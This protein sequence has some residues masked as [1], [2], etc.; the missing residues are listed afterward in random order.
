MQYKVV[1]K[2]KKFGKSTWVEGKMLFLPGE[3]SN[4]VCG[5]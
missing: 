4:K 5:R 3:K 1:K 2:C